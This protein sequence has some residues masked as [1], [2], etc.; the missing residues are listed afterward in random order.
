MSL[1]LFDGVLVDAVPR[2]DGPV[3]IHEGHAPTAAHTSA[4]LSAAPFELDDHRPKS[5]RPSVIRHGSAEYFTFWNAFRRGADGQT[6]PGVEHD[7]TI[8]R[9]AADGYNLGCLFRPLPVMKENR[10]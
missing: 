7:A 5:F 3:R 1:P 2:R 10:R 9:Y 4:R 8:A 6:P